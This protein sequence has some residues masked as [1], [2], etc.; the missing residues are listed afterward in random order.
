MEEFLFA[1]GFTF[2]GYL[3]HALM[4]TA[5]DIMNEEDDYEDEE[6][7]EEKEESTEEKESPV[8]VDEKVDVIPDENANNNISSR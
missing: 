5:K 2:F 7:E 8:D 1:V 3:L 6:V 4:V